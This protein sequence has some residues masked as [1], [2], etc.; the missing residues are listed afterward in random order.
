[1]KKISNILLCILLSCNFVQ[2]SFAMMAEGGAP[3]TKTSHRLEQS[4]K[5][6]KPAKETA[7]KSFQSIKSISATTDPLM[8]PLHTKTTAVKADVTPIDLLSQ[9]QNSDPL[10][11]ISLN[12]SSV[13]LTTVKKGLY[14][15]NGP[16]KNTLTKD[17]AEQKI[18]KK[19]EEISKEKPTPQGRDR[20]NGFLKYLPE[21]LLPKPKNKEINKNPEVKVEKI[22]HTNDF[23]LQDFNY[24]R[25][26]IALA[27]SR[28]G[29]L[30]RKRTLNDSVDASLP[31]TQAINKQIKDFDKA[32]LVGCKN[33]L[34]NLKLL[35]SK[36]KPGEKLSYA[37][38][39]KFAKSYVQSQLETILPKSSSLEK[40][41]SFNKEIEIELVN[42]IMKSGIFD[43]HTMIRPVEGKLTGNS[44]RGAL[45]R[46]TD[47]LQDFA[48]M[49]DSIMNK[50]SKGDPIHTT[51]ETKIDSQANSTVIM[52]KIDP[53]TKKTITTRSQ[54]DRTGT[55]MMRALIIDDPNNSGQTSFKTM[56]DPKT[57]K[58]TTYMV[59][60]LPKRNYIPKKNEI[61]TSDSDYTYIK[62]TLTSVESK[63]TNAQYA[64]FQAVTL[65]KMMLK[66]SL[67]STK[68]I[69][70]SAITHP[71]P[72]SILFGC[73]APLALLVKGV[74]LAAGYKYEDPTIIATFGTVVELTMGNKR[75]MLSNGQ[76][77]FSPGSTLHE[78]FRKVNPLGS[79]EKSEQDPNNE[80]YGFDTD[81]GNALVYG[82]K[83][84]LP[85]TFGDS[86]VPKAS[87][88]N[89]N[90]IAPVN[91][92]HAFTDKIS[93][94]LSGK[95]S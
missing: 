52:T 53:N 17:S 89:A 73:I 15:D 81:I 57:K 36:L 75:A 38:Q 66:L 85:D 84:L 86:L 45:K 76:Y 28:V 90:G 69:A 11:E 9:T 26:F 88:T 10:T 94:K 82:V 77:V 6:P 27:K 2:L 23:T 50:I 32:G 34:T 14:V 40:T 13:E 3:Q 91:S 37:Q 63:M 30:V 24:I 49:K 59:E 1:M 21:F 4:F 41:T 47:R 33:G 18:I 42:E 48:T 44:K 29:V 71:I 56:I 46:D 87:I 12:G 67:W 72:Q 43:T 35:E 65:G 78:A 80:Y 61:V 60:R 83:K 19:T 58:S 62:T 51:F 70:F 39:E 54:I 74:S 5:R 22:E 55:L 7:I 20:Y 25:D 68:Q 93:S 79:K 95:A 64:I 92:V 16:L 8:S 31:D